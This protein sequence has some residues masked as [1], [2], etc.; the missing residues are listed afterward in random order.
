MTRVTVTIEGEAE[1][2]R[3][4]LAR[5][6]GSDGGDTTPAPEVEV[7]PE[8]QPWEREDLSRLWSSLTDPARRVLAEVATRPQGYPLQELE[9]AL[10]LNMRRIGG[11]LSSVGHAMRRYFRQG[12][13]YTR[14]WPLQGDRNKRRYLMEDDVAGWIREFAAEGGE[15]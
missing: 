8:P 11:N 1:E 4:A 10:G 15:A 9:E 5:L 14:E 2:I 13:H 12:G 6:L 7:A 3:E